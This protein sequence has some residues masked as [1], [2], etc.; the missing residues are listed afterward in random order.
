MGQDSSIDRSADLPNFLT[1]GCPR[2]KDLLAYLRLAR[3]EGMD[4]YSCPYTTHYSSF[5]VLFHF[6]IPTLNPRPYSALHFLFPSFIPSY[7]WKPPKPGPIWVAVKELESRCH[8]GEPHGPNK[9][10]ENGN[11]ES[12]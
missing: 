6:L 5:H 8:A 2:L 4:P 12:V 9:E 3:N 11:Y 1:V 10:T 7:S